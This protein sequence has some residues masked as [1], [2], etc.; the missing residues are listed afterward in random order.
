MSEP[1]TAEYDISEDLPGKE[2]LE[3]LRVEHIV[4]LETVGN[5]PMEARIAGQAFPSETTEDGHRKPE[6]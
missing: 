3:P 2:A 6:H 4:N 1:L 5:E